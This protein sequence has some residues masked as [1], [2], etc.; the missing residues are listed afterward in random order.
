MLPNSVI[1]ATG[2]NWKLGLA[3][4]SL[5]VG[6]FAPLFHG[7]G[8]S[9]TGGTVLACAGYAY[10]LLAIRCPDCG[11]RW[12]WQAALQAELYKPLMTQSNCPSCKHEFRK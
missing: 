6:S 10:G 5:L 12:F 4:L 1:R 9:W 7:S 3:I 2:Q 11:I 8:I